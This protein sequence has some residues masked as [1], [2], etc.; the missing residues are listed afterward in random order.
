MESHAGVEAGLF[1]MQEIL[2][3]S[4]RVW[5]HARRIIEDKFLSSTLIPVWRSLD[6]GKPV[7]LMEFTFGE[8][9]NADEETIREFYE[10]EPDWFDLLSIAS[11]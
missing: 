7:R 8:I 1:S 5:P 9:A 6:P 4:E 10:R 2:K 11:E 3:L